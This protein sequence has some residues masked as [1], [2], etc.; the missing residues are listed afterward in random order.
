MTPTAVGSEA[1]WVR[2]ESVVAVA[3]AVAVASELAAERCAFE[4]LARHIE[5]VPAN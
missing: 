4:I 3:V 2:S 1:D 5:D